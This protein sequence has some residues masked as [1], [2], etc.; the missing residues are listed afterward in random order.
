MQHCEG[1]LVICIAHC[2]KFCKPTCWTSA[3][4]SSQALQLYI[5]S[6]EPLEVWA[7]QPPEYFLLWVQHFKS[8]TFW[9]V[10]MVLRRAVAQSALILF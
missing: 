10:G 4:D 7:R 3:W 2:S 5:N 9:E 1:I 6:E 8:F